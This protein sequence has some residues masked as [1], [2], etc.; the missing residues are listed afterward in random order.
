MATLAS[1]GPLVGLTPGLIGE[2]AQGVGT[3]GL[4]QKEES[5]VVELMN[6]LTTDA[7]RFADLG[8]GL[9]ERAIQSVVPHHNRAQARREGRDQ[10]VEGLLDLGLMTRLRQIALGDEVRRRADQGERFLRSG[11]CR[12]DRAGN[13]RD[14]VTAQAR[15]AGRVIALQSV[16]QTDPS[17]VER[18]G[19][20]EGPPPL[21]PNDPT[22][23]IL[24]TGHLLRQG[25]IPSA[26]GQRGRLT[27]V[28]PPTAVDS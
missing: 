5:L 23:E 24:V 8:E 2:Q 4:G 3:G 12:P 7:P 1:H 26:R 15:P 25:R 11:D 16:P 9:G 17:G 19:E 22:H 20:G 18:I 6:P 28:I 21:L 27:H 10:S 13:R 14:G